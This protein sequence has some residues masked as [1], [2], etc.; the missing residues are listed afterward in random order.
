MLRQ[1]TWTALSEGFVSVWSACQR[2]RWL[3]WRLLGNSC[4]LYFCMWKLLLT[5]SSSLYGKR[6]G[7]CGLWRREGVSAEGWTKSAPFTPIQ[8]FR[9]GLVPCRFPESL[10]SVVTGR[11]Y[12]RSSTEQM[13]V[14]CCIWLLF[15][16]Y[17]RILYVLSKNNSL[18]KSSEPSGNN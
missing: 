7:E 1:Y 5:T 12:F 15:V 11:V 17:Q 10:H 4:M 18:T 16:M 3:G 9:V 6:A 8:P 2:R 13:G 14:K